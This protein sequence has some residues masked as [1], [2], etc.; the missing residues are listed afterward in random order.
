MKALEDFYCL[1]DGYEKPKRYL[2]ADVVEWRFSEE[3][4]KPRWSLSSS[5]YVKEAIKN[6]E[7]EL[8]KSNLRLP[9]NAS[10]PMPLKYRP[11]LD[12]SPLLTDEAV[13]YYKSQISIL[14]WAVELGRID[15]YIDTALLSQHLVHPRQGH[16]GAVYHIYIY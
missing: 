11:E 7:L 4:D 5:Q 1:K 3:V 16:L 13:N 6:V 2:G 12:T 10:T 9:S 15:I 14:R 8:A